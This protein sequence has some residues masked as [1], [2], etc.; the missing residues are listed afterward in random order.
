MLLSPS[1]VTRFLIVVN[2]TPVDNYPKYAKYGQTKTSTNDLVQAL[3][4]ENCMSRIAASTLETWMKNIFM[5]L[6]AFSAH[7][8]KLKDT[9]VLQANVTKDQLFSLFSDPQISAENYFDAFQLFKV[10][11]KVPTRTA[12]Q[13]ARCS[14]YRSI[15]TVERNAHC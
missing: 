3:Q 11:L 13:H 15:G 8:A 12:D 7:I 4:E 5:T 9:A 10:S 6:D 1:V 14:H 2:S